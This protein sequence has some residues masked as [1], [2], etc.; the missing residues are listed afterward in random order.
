MEDIRRFS[1][2]RHRLQQ[3]C[4]SEMTVPSDTE[5]E[6]NQSDHW[7][8]TR[9]AR[10]SSPISFA[11][12]SDDDAYLPPEVDQWRTLSCDRKLQHQS[13]D[14]SRNCMGVVF[15][16]ENPT[17]DAY[18]FA[19]NR[20]LELLRDFAPDAPKQPFIAFADSDCLLHVTS[21][22]HFKWY[23]SKATSRQAKDQERIAE[24][25]EDVERLEQRVHVLR[26]SRYSKEKTVSKEKTEMDSRQASAIEFWK[27]QVERMRE[28]EK[29]F[30]DTRADL[31]KRDRQNLKLKEE[32]D[33]L[34]ED[35]RTIREDTKNDNRRQKVEDEQKEERRQKFRRRALDLLES[36]QAHIDKLRA[37]LI[38]IAEGRIRVEDSA[39][40]KSECRIPLGKRPMLTTE[41]ILG[42]F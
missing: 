11:S 19:R 30:L 38:N 15:E 26:T 7:T 6:G 34:R 37:E 41:Q 21:N 33:N 23:V 29:E 31:V 14:F 27:E 13:R 20:M 40:A 12:D 18:D 35:I 8:R 32:I 36:R 24:L 28:R 10:T 5:D 1:A 42:R 4:E 3:Y 39:I 2:L 25:E 17:G 22:F 16:K 9:P